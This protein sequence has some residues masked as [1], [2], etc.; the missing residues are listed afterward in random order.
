MKNAFGLRLI[1]ILNKM[2]NKSEN[3]DLQVSN[4]L[5]FYNYASNATPFYSFILEKNSKSYH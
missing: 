1:D 2:V 5:K 3:A 4:K